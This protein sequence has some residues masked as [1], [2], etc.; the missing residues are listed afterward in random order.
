LEES[1]KKALYYGYKG[2]F[3]AWESQNGYDAC[4]DFNV[5]DVFTH[6][7]VRTYFKDKQVHISS[8]V[9]YGLINYYKH[10]G[11]VSIMFEGGLRTLIECSLF[12]YSYS[13]FNHIKLRYEL[14]DVIG[15]DEYH[16]RVNNNAYTNYMAH[17]TVTQTLKLLEELSVNYS[18]KVSKILKD[19]PADIRQKLDDWAQKLYLPKQNNAGVIEQ[20]DGYYKNEDVNVN[21]VRQRLVKPNEYWG[22]STGVA[23]ATRVIKQADSVMLVNLLPEY[24]SDNAQAANY[25]YYLPYTEH[26]SSLSACMY[27]LAACKAGKADDAWEWFIKTAEIDLVGG[28]KQWAGEIYIGG[29]HPAA[30]GGAW[31]TA[32]YGFAGMKVVDGCVSFKPNLPKNIK[33]MSF[34]ILEKGVHYNVKIDACGAQK[35]KINEV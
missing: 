27:A 15:P 28:G 23:T 4:S 3:Y 6:R 32:V 35:V 20:F 5:V 8:A 7:P 19:Y 31:M 21:T 25:N 13:Y 10:S 34:K 9:A 33:S 16:E 22:G 12:Y 1:K 2:A 17:Y 11:D 24:F 18:E 26:G 29:T 30:N 14:L